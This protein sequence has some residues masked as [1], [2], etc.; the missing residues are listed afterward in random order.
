MLYMLKLE[1]KGPHKFQI[2]LRLSPL[3]GN[4]WC[5]LGLNSGNHRMWRRSRGLR[6]EA[7]TAFSASLNMY[8]LRPT[9]THLRESS[10][11]SPTTATLGCLCPAPS[12]WTGGLSIPCWVLG[13][14]PSP[15]QMGRRAD[16]ER[17]G[18]GHAGRGGQGFFLKVPS[19]YPAHGR[20]PFPR[21]LSCFNCLDFCLKHLPWMHLLFSVNS[22]MFIQFQLSFL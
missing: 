16:S 1:P 18:W 22:H 7:L 12:V 15:F 17:P 5:Q 9:L 10:A 14:R 2:L 20:R 4:L 3:L 6:P 13:P 21:I 8:P 11:P 19:I